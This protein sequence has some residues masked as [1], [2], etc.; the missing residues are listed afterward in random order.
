VPADDEAASRHALARGIHAPPLSSY[1]A[2][3]RP[4]RGFVLGFAATAERDMPRAARGLASA[5][6]AARRGAA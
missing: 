2:S 5:I 1:Y 6:E 4:Q 3:T